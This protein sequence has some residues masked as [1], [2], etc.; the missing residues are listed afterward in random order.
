MFYNMLIPEVGLASRGYL[1]ALGAPLGGH[2]NESEHAF[3]G[4][5]PLS[6][7]LRR[8]ESSRC[9]L[10]GPGPPPGTVGRFVSK[11]LQ[12][13]RCCCSKPWKADCLTEPLYLD[14]LALGGQ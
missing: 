9:P 2:P 1:G 13:L 7:P 10:Q 14:R 11:V 12:L 8:A 4:L 6:W 3:N 5:G